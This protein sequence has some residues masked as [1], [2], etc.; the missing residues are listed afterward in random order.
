MNWFK[1]LFR[2]AKGWL[3]PPLPKR[4]IITESEERIGAAGADIIGRQAGQK[5]NRVHIYR[6]PYG[7]PIR[8]CDWTGVELK[9]IEEVGRCQGLGGPAE[10]IT[11]VAALD[12]R[13]SHTDDIICRHCKAVVT[14]KRS[15]IGKGFYLKGA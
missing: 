5:R 11:L 2:G 13:Q 3:T 1:C 8:L 4:E 6:Q 15:S 12:W 10:P 7:Y 14:G 9:D